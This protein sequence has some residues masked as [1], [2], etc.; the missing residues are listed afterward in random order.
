M[1]IRAPSCDVCGECYL[2]TN[3]FRYTYA[4]LPQ[5][6]EQDASEEV[7]LK[8]VEQE[9]EQQRQFQGKSK[10][11]SQHGRHCSLGNQSVKSN[12]SD[13]DDAFCVV[14]IAQQED[15]EI[16][17]ATSHAEEEQEQERK[18]NETVFTNASKHVVM[19]RVMRD[20]AREETTNAKRCYTSKAPHE[21]RLYVLIGDY[22]Q[23]LT[24]LLFTI[25]C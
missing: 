11:I 19:A 24:V 8:Y 10:C 14:P 1:K 13:D 22:G 15:A 20:M 23:N 3:V 7:A 16:E 21:I 12:D 5:G 25:D 9:E 4:F 17:A 6:P 2:Y 18:S